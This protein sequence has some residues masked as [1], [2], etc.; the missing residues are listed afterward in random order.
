[1][2]KMII[3]VA[4]FQT[5]SSHLSCDILKGSHDDVVPPSPTLSMAPCPHPGSHNA[6]MYSQTIVRLNLSVKIACQAWPAVEYI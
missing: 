1:M 6:P 2:P 5:A 4:R 3:E